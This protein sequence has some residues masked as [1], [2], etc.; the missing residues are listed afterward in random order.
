MQKGPFYLKIDYNVSI[1]IS[2]FKIL[3][4]KTRGKM[5]YIANITFNA[6][7]FYII[8]PTV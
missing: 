8:I 1:I 2:I 4:L 6:D 5:K 3:V 7:V